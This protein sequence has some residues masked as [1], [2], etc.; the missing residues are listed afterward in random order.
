MIESNSS[1]SGR[2]IFDF[3]VANQL[4]TNL[5]RRISMCD[6]EQRNRIKKNCSDNIMDFISAMFLRIPEGSSKGRKEF[7]ETALRVMDEWTPIRNKKS[8]DGAYLMHKLK[9][10]SD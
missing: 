8:N 3:D 2:I 5:D 10:V 6:E 9:N 1:A 7:Q 4:L